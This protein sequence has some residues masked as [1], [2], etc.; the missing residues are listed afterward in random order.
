M[1][2]IVMPTTPAFASSRFGLR[3][4][5]QRHVSPLN[6]AV[7]T[8]EL[9]GALWTADYELPPMNQN[10]AAAWRATRASGSA[11]R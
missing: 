7:Q 6:Q 4:N 2:A 8:L 3:A 10:Q 9:P 5:T 11:A 1:A